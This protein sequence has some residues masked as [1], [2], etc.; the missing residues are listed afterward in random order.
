[1]LGKVRFRLPSAAQ[2]IAAAGPLDG[3][4]EALRRAF[5]PGEDFHP[6]PEPGPHD[7]LAHHV[8]TGQ[9]FDQF[10]ASGP[11]TPQ[12][13]RNVLYLQP[14]GD[15]PVRQSPGLDQLRR[16]AAAFFMLSVR[17][18][19]PVD[20]ASTRITQRRNPW[21]GHVQWL[22][23]DLLELLRR[24]MPADAFAL[25]GITMTD[26]YPEPSWNFVFGQAWVSQRVGVYSFARYD[27]EFYGQPRRSD[28]MQLLL[29]RSIKVL[30]HETAHMFGLA[31]CIWYR[32]L[33]NGSNHLEES[34]ARPLHL[35]PVDLR[36]LH[37]SI[38]FDIAER[39]R[40]LLAFYRSAGFEDQARWVERRLAHLE[41]RAAGR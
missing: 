17:L 14:L 12:P 30:A 18:L 8:E 37:W 39:Y 10:L 33:M 6:L 9:T 21:T 29:R 36:K 15:F 35:C 38:G 23:G 31:H 41:G 16:F 24:Q 3:L 25:L 7:W 13:G 32:C 2:R 20:P 22:T 34:D 19:P 28:W 26:L 11:R 27:P 5:E 1:M 4:P 40:R